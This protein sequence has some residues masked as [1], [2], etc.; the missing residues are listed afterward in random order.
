MI[1]PPI[2]LFFSLFAHIKP[3]LEILNDHSGAFQS[4]GKPEIIQKK[5]DNE[6]YFIVVEKTAF[7]TKE[8]AKKFIE[9]GE[10]VHSMK[11]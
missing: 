8:D 1:K 6:D 5:I 11:F 4:I 10:R 9:I 3:I 2:K 7:K